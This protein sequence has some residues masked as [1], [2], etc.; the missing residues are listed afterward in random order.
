MREQ[1]IAPIKPFLTGRTLAALR[2]EV[3]TLLTRVPEHGEQLPYSS[4]AATAIGR[5]HLNDDFPALA[6]FFSADWMRTIAEEFFAAE[7]YS[8]N[9]DVIAVKD[10][11]GTTHAAR[12]P[13]YDR[14]PNLKFFLYLSDV[15]SDNGPFACL[16]GSH[17]HAKRVEDRRR[18]ERVLPRQD[19]TRELPGELTSGLLPVLGPAGTLLVIDS[20]VIHRGLPVIDGFRLAVRGR[21]YAPEYAPR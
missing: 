5:R 1:G 16:P 11:P 21:S 7:D 18:R 6:E 13:H 20:D 10:L 17:L 8:F 14:T 2:A 19:E 9:H 4:G 15:G 12:T 3:G